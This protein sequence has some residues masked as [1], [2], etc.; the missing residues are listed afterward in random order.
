MRNLVASIQ[1][2]GGKDGKIDTEK[3]GQT[4]T[5]RDR[6]HTNTEIESWEDI[7]KGERR[8]RHRDRDEV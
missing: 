2:D 7:N 4:D 1:R 8:K 6:Q 5:K 3:Q